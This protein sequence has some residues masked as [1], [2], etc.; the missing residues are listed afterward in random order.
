MG[1]QCVT[2]SSGG[3]RSTL[4]PDPTSP[5]TLPHHHCS[6]VGL[7]PESDVRVAPDAVEAL[8]CAAESHL[9]GLFEGANL[10]AVGCKRQCL[11]PSDIQLA[12]R[13]AATESE[14]L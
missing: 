13:L 6:L 3:S 12:L 1:A 14:Q 4:S 5:N 10:V 8:R 9:V 7:A 2:E 11:E